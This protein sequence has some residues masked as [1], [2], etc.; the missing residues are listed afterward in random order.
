MKS[1]Y[2]GDD[3]QHPLS[4]YSSLSLCRHHSL[5]SKLSVRLTV[6]LVYALSLSLADAIS[7]SHGCSL[8]LADALSLSQ[9]CSLSHVS[10][11]SIYPVVCCRIHAHRDGVN[12]D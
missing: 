12:M 10:P 7:L 4:L 11:L 2:G 8:S 5:E 1:K 6:V 3:G 9:G